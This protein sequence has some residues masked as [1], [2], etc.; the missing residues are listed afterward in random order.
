V[1]QS[2]RTPGGAFALLPILLLVL[3]AALAFSGQAMADS[4][5]QCAATG[6]ESVSTPRDHYQAGEVA[7]I[8][9]GGYAAGCGLQVDVERPDGVV[10]SFP[11]TTDVG[12]NFTLDYQVP[13]PPGVPGQYRIVVRGVDGAELASTTFEDAPAPQFD[14]A[15]SHVP[16][17]GSR[18]FTA[19][20]RNTANSSSDTARCIRVTTPGS[21]TVSSAGFVVA[22]PGTTGPWTLTTGANFVQLRTSGAGIFGSATS[23]NNWA[24]F[25]ITANATAAGTN[26][27]TARMTSTNA[28]CASGGS[29]DQL[30]VS[31]AQVL[32][33]QY[34]ADFRNAGNA[35]IPA[36][37]VLEDTSQAYRVRI[38]RTAGTDDL[39]H[40]AIALPTC[41]SS[42]TGIST[43]DSGPPAYTAELTDNMLRLVPGTKLAANGDWVQAHFTATA[44]CPTGA[45]EFRTASWKNTS[46]ETAQGDIFQLSPGTN[47]PTLTVLSANVAPTVAANNAAV[48]VNEGQTAANSGVWGDANLTDTVTL[49]ASVGTVVKSGTNAAGTWSWSH[50]T[51]DGPAQTQVVTI[52]ASDGTASTS[53]TF[54]LNVDNV[55]P[56]ATF[57]AP[58]SVNEGSTIGLSLSA[59]S[60]PSSVDTAAGFEYRFSCDNGTTWTAWTSSA[61]HSCGT[62]DDGTENVNGEIRDKDGGVNSYSASVGVENVPP[63]A[64]FNAPASVDE[65]S[66]IALSLTDVVDPGS[67]A[68]EYRF[69]CGADDWGDWGSSASASCATSDN[70]TVVVQGQVRD[71]DDGLSEEYSASVTVNN[72][73]PSA[74]FTN[75]GPVDEGSNIAL[76]LTDVVDP[77][78][79]DTHEYRFKCGADEWSDWG[80]SGSASCATSDNGSVVVKGQVQDDDGGASPEYSASVTVDNV[81]PSA[82]FN[83]NGPV[84]EGSNIAL[85]LTH[86]VD[87]G[88]ADTHE[89]RFKCG[90][91]DWSDWGSSG[92]ASCATSDNGSVVVKGQVQDDDGGASP[93]YSA[94]V[95]VDNVAPSA[96]FNAPAAVNE[97]SSIGLS[98][99]SASDPSPADTAAGFEYRFSCDDGT[100][101]TA[102]SPSVSHSC[103]TTD[104]GTRDV[105]GEIRD[106][107]LDASTYG[108]AVA[109]TNVAPSA[110]F[111]A[112]DSVN[113]G[114]NVN[115]SLTDVVDPGIAD[116]HEYR[117]SCDGGATWTPW[118]GSSTHACPTIDNGTVEVRGQV[119][120]DDDGTS[121]VYADSVTVN[122]V[123]PS[124]T[125][126]APESANEG[127]H[128]DLSLTDVVDP[129]TADTHEYR[130]S[131]DGGVTWTLYG[132][133]ASHTCATSDNGTR[134]VKGQVMDDDGGESAEYSA[135]VTVNNVAPTATFSAPDAV[136]EGSSFNLSLTDPSDPS[137]ADTAAGFQYR[138]S[139]DDGTTW[140]PWSPSNTHVCSTDDNGTQN[141]KG[142]VRDKDEGTSSYSDS[143]AVNNVAP[144]ATF[145]APASVNEGSSFNVSLTA[146]S[147][148]SSADT[149]AGFEY[150][151]DCG[152]GSGYGA[153]SANNG[154]SC[155][156]TDDGARSVG[157]KIR[158]KDGGVTEYTATVAVANVSPTLTSLT[159]SS[160][161]VLKGSSVSV[162]GTYTD[163]GTD[164]TFTC[165]VNW[166]EPTGTPENVV[167]G[168]ASCSSTH[169]YTA[170][171]SYTVSMKV[172]DDDGGESNTLTVIITVYD[173]SAGGFVTGGGWIVSPQGSYA[174]D[175]AASGRANFGFNSQ[176]KKGST[177]PTG[178]TEFQLH[179]ATFK[180]HSDAYEVLVVS[181]HKAQ[182]RGTGRINGTS[183]YKFVLTAYD[184]QISGGGGADRFRIKIT[185]ISDGVVVYDSRMGTSEDMDEANPL[186]LGGGSIVIHKAK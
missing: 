131:C 143:V 27:W 119:S 149:A 81:A 79:A 147:D 115:L 53:T 56:S 167:G 74:S 50:P 22:S 165:I 130:F 148:P 28:D 160:Y 122:N 135:S 152:D 94:S 96:T 179:F 3:A 58:A 107:D 127:S 150:A 10:E 30:G 31:V 153:Y 42:I 101:W 69:K 95:T 181:G 12:G 6:M 173:P 11:A 116:T 172:R 84:E 63:G 65:G 9:G 137:S 99:S 132:S 97:G 106:K 47:H 2:V 57:N 66:N 154:R 62:T 120:D 44:D 61:S 67:D 54:Q 59:P 76:S 5:V 178:E 164:D 77:G 102:W 109:V 155:P 186:A 82:S 64:T 18:V 113:E 23:S 29:S 145:N 45:H 105:N 32:P 184:G 7:Q 85:S 17:I 168:S 86:V 68:H 100:T 129:G 8:S 83:N 93:E 128:I 125:F 37:T 136:D 110:T 140:T 162:T 48:T 138:F 78:T 185:R 26:T 91:S 144:T 4:G 1:K 33:R 21:V 139:C 73:A 19:V 156:T 126:N 36:P 51:T 170:Q 13:P 52:T 55:A 80:S 40:I 146:P 87:P 60:D 98:F 121:D 166:D 89:Y 90:D 161:L 175:P 133:N 112:P 70:G 141:V 14:I 41:F 71:D 24:R 35:I 43:S 16:A 20:V 151:F 108:S 114:S 123:A 169:T 39:Q 15:P 158:D 46:P 72:V 182:Y 159:P 176:Y 180:F 177:V 134:T 25:E 183:G 111:N 75:N 171:G 142:E 118:G 117:F 124:A 88:T 163:P 34:T 174:A 38:T 104:N 92:S 49:S 103:A 157:G